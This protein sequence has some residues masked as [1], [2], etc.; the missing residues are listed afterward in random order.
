MYN[1]RMIQSTSE[2][3]S[4]VFHFEIVCEASEPEDVTIQQGEEGP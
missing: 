4:A 2:Q 3:C 1:T